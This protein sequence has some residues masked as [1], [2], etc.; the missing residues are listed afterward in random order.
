MRLNL[1]AL[2]ILLALHTTV[3]AAGSAMTAATNDLHKWCQDIT[4]AIPKI[5]L[6][7][8]VSAE[9]KPWAKSVKGRHIMLHELTP[10]GAV[11]ARVLVIG[12]IHGDELTSVSIVF[13]WIELLK[14]EP[15]MRY[16]W[17]VIPVLNPE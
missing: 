14:Q 3:C 17:R 4:R 12:G 5:K 6:N 1:P 2:I 16:H 8:C 13:R 9:L 7:T 11:T 10:A 15:P